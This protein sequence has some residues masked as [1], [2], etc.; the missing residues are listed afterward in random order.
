LISEPYGNER[1]EKQTETAAGCKRRQSQ[2]VGQRTPRFATGE[3]SADQSER[4]R[5]A[6]NGDKSGYAMQVAEDDGHLDRRKDARKKKSR[7]DNE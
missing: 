7:A 1:S 2:A 5:R 4:N 6:E 3:A